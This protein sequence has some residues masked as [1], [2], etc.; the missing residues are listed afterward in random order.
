MAL[1]INKINLIKIFIILVESF[2][3]NE[4]IKVIYNIMPINI[5]KIKNILISPL[6]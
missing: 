1:K 2:I 6:F 3:N 5:P 4:L